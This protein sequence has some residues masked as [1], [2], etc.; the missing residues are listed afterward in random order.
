M[1]DS[2][3]INTEDF[4]TEFTGELAKLTTDE[5]CD[6][7]QIAKIDDLIKA[8]YNKTYYEKKKK[9]LKTIDCEICYGTY[10]NYSKTTH[11]K[12]KKHLKALEI[13]NKK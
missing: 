12:S 5:Y 8:K 1:S 7:C 2:D 10:N 6:E 13:K 11:L 3:S 4:V 9:D